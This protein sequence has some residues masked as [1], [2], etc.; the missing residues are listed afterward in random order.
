[1]IFNEILAANC[2]SRSHQSL[3]YWRSTSGFEVDFIIEDTLDVE[4]KTSKKIQDR[5]LRGLKALMDEKI[6]SKY[7]LV[8]FDEISRVTEG[9]E[10][11]H[12]QEFIR[13]LPTWMSQ[14]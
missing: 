10:I 11:M 7:V 8:S 5:D 4:V 9:I 1:F 14:L 3:N 2:Y 13:Q 6:C 12:W